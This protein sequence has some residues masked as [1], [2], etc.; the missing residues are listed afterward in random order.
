MDN[1]SKSII[2]Q[3]AYKGNIELLKDPNRKV[4]SPKEFEDKVWEHY[5]ILE[6]LI[7]RAINP[8]VGE[9]ELFYAENLIGTSTLD[10]NQKQEAESWLTDKLKWED[11]WKL[12]GRL[13]INQLDGVDLPSASQTKLNEGLKSK[14][15]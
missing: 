7:E 8:Y 9:S 3:V 1:T 4:V 11:Y 2:L 12:V 6:R 5:L 13:K 14:G 10:E 15:K